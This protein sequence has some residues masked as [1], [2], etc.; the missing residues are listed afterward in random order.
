MGTGKKC[1]NTDQHW[2]FKQSK[3]EP[4]CTMTHKIF[5]FR[6]KSMKQL[7]FEVLPKEGSILWVGNTQSI[8]D[9]GPLRYGH[10]DWPVGRIPPAES[11]LPPAVGILSARHVHVGRSSRVSSLS[12]RCPTTHKQRENVT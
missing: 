8:R 7:K 6:C 12:V 1:T 10:R 2:S 11:T 4:K 3:T 5:L 9:W